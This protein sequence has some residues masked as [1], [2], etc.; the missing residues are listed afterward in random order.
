MRF[1][2][3]V[4]VVVGTASVGGEEDMADEGFVLGR[5]LKNSVKEERRR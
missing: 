4:D 2:T 5:W 1:G 3:E